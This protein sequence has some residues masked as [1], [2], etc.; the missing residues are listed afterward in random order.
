MVLLKPLFFFCQM[1][2]TV[3]GVFNSI[4]GITLSEGIVP[5]TKNRGE[6]TG[7]EKQTVSS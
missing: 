2:P 5:L 7:K 6:K 1:N 4:L 3:K